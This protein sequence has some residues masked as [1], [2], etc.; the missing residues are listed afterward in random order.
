MF[1]QSHSDLSGQSRQTSGAMGQA[2]LECGAPTQKVKGSL[3]GYLQMRRFTTGHKPPE[4]SATS[5]SCR[6]PGSLH[7][8]L[9]REILMRPE[10]CSLQT[11][12]PYHRPRPRLS[13]PSLSRCP[14]ARPPPGV[15]CS[16]QI[17]VFSE[18]PVSTFCMPLCKVT[19][20][21]FYR[22]ASGH[23]A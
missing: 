23:G 15:R 14:A 20:R 17:L 7:P 13:L 3:Q 12:Q 19:H 5:P 2:P 9:W 8:Q 10:P 6:G 1:N 22:E 16:I 4:A 18:V 11:A 21:S